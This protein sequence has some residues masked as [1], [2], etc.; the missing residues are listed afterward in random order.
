MTHSESWVCGDPKVN[1]NRKVGWGQKR[2]S[3]LKKGGE[4]EN[5]RALGRSIGP[6]HGFP[7]E[8]EPWKA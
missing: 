8:E 5:N 6:T 4:K 2:S 1:K 3:K 7:L